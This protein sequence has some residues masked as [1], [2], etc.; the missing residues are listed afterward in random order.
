[1]IKIVVGSFSMTYHIMDGPGSG[2]WDCC[3]GMGQSLLDSTIHSSSRQY[4]SDLGLRGAS[5]MCR[6]HHHHKE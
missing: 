1:M 5:L 3:I 6:T 4:C 2:N